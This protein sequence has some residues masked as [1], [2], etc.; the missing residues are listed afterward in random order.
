MMVVCSFSGRKQT[1]RSMIPKLHCQT[2]THMSR[3]KQE[4][5]GP[6]SFISLLF[7]EIQIIATVVFFVWRI[8]LLLYFI[9]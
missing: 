6:G 4:I 1:L 2:K 8:T 5:R 3:S 7:T 9:L